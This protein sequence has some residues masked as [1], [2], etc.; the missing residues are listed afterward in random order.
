MDFVIQIVWIERGLCI[1]PGIQERG[2]GCGERGEC[3]ERYIPENGN[4]AKQSGECRQIFRGMSSN[5]PGNVAIFWC[6]GR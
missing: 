1:K 6:K 4:V 2:T 5:I 3:G